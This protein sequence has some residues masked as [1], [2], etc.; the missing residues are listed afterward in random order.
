MQR[1]RRP[2]R[3]LISFVTGAYAL[4]L[5]LF[6]VLRLLVGDSWWWLAFLGNFTPFYFA[7]LLV[8]LPLA[9][10]ARA[11]RGLLLMLPLA[12]LG[13]LWFGRL[14]LPK[15]QADAPTDTPTLRVITLN[16]WGDNPDLT[17]IE[18]WLRDQQADV[19]VTIELPPVWAE[20][21]DVPA[22]AAV[23]PQQIRSVAQGKY[24]GGMI[25]SA[26]PVLASEQF[27]LGEIPQQRVVVEFDGQP[28]AIYGIHLY[29]PV[30]EKPHLP[31]PANFYTNG[32]FGYDD[33]AQRAQISALI[34]RLQAEPLPYVVAGDFN[35]ID[36]SA[37]YGQLAAL[38]GDS[39][40][41]A[42]VGLGTSW[43]NMQ[44]LGLP[45]LI[46]PLVRIDYIWHSSAFRALAAAQGPYLG[47]D[48]LP[49]AATLARR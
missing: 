32:I 38:M 42:G 47:S 34:Q 28:L 41:E 33:S 48:H 17:H 45:T 14:Y 25:F 23:Y 1:Q 29:L 24:W 21:T 8:L 4:G 46:P 30:G 11:R 37:S 49:L 16:V 35:M 3:A 10:L 6:V 19:A 18:N 27:S 13:V 40:R 20:G 12:L 36:Q 26:L 44:A 7:A 15:A 39:F 22:L 5:L 31:V 43:P 9:L 2:L